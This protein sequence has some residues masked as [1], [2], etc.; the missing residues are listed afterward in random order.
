MER[1]RAGYLITSGTGGIREKKEKG[2]EKKREGRETHEK[3]KI[4]NL[5]RL[6]RSFFSLNFHHRSFI[7]LFPKRNPETY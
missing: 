5:Y 4:Q 1:N 3:R 2:E 6:K 7:L